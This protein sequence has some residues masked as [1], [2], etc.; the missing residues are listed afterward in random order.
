MAPEVVWSYHSTV[1]Y[2]HS[3]PLPLP[4]KFL[5]LRLVGLVMCCRY[6]INTYTAQYRPLVLNW[7]YPL[8]F[9]DTIHLIESNLNS[10]EIVAAL[11]YQST[12]PYIRSRPLPLPN[13]FPPLSFVGLVMCRRYSINT[14][15]AQ[16]RPLVLNWYYPLR[17][18]DT[19]HLIE[20]NLNS[21]EIVAVWPY[22]STVPYIHSRPLPL[23]YKH[24][25]G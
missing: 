23:R 9:H 16:Y 4:N 17:F 14:Y 11:P 10:T 20:S 2:I 1:P 13:K 21:T 19:I 24:L 6:S 8:R 7:Y 3:H 15:T 22:H 5:L 25:M 12:V 18:H